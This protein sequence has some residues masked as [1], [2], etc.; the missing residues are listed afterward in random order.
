MRLYAHALRAFGLG[1]AGGSGVSHCLEQQVRRFIR[2]NPLAPYHTGAHRAQPHL[3]K[4]ATVNPALVP[5]SLRD[6]VFETACKDE[7]MGGGV[8]PPSIAILMAQG[9]VLGLITGKNIHARALSIAN[10]WRCLVC[11]ANR[12][13]Y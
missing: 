5:L 9:K 7:D 6:E 11:S 4:H 10:R 3:C 8:S 2:A 13:N 1:I 12:L